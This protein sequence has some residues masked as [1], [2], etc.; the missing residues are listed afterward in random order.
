MK[1]VAIKNKLTGIAQAWPTTLNTI[2]FT[3]QSIPYPPTKYVIK[4]TTMTGKNVNDAIEMFL[5]SVNPGHGDT[6][7]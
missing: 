2:T 7:R 5:K 6:Y 4:A 3:V 1:Q